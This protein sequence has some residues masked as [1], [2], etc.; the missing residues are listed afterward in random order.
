MALQEDAS[1]QREEA[2]VAHLTSAGDARLQRAAGVRS[3]GIVSMVMGA[4]AVA[5]F[6]EHGKLAPL[7]LGGAAVVA[8]AV[9]LHYAGPMPARAQRRQLLSRW[10][11]R[12]WEGRLGE[13]FFRLASAPDTR[14]ARGL[15]G[16][17]RRRSGA[18]SEPPVKLTDDLDAAR[19]IERRIDAF[20]QAHDAP[21]AQTNSQP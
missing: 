21:A 19:S 3:L 2:G 10:F 12:L 5:S 15:L 8:G 9:V 6:F 17:A 18:G 4:V 7:L 20:V 11:D 13:W 1:A 16:R 14:V